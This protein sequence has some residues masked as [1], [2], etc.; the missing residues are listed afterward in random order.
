MLLFG[1][2]FIEND[3][4]YH[5]SSVDAVI[6]TPPSST[7][8]LEFNEENLD[9]ISY[10]NANSIS[11]ALSVH[12]IT[13]LIYASALDAKYIIIEKDLASSAQSIVE[14]YLFD[15]KLLVTIENDDEIEELAIIGVDGV[16]YSSAIVKINS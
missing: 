1:H 3:S 5:I 15:A 6:N 13:Q 7:L 16:I 14:S 10:L 11:F 12:N 9:I 8:Y 2:R 4:F